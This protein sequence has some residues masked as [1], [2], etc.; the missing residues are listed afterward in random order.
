MSMRTT[1][2]AFRCPRAARLSPLAAAIGLALAPVI[3]P[4]ATITVTSTADSGPGTLRQAIFDANANC[5]SDPSPTIDFTGTGPFTV[6][7]SSQ[8]P[9]FFCP[10]GNFNPT[11]DGGGSI[12]GS[13]P[14]GFDHHAVLNG[15]GSAVCGLTFPANFTYGG[16]LT[17]RGMRI[18]NFTYGSLAAGVCGVMELHENLLTNNTVGAL[19][20][21][22]NAVVGDSTY[23][24][25]VIVN[26][27]YGVWVQFSSASIENNKIGTPNGT[28]AL[29]N[30][31]G[32]YVYASNGTD[33]SNN[34]I[35]GNTTAGVYFDNDYGGTVTGNYIGTTAD[36]DGAL[37]NGTGIYHD[38]GGSSSIQNNVI[39][40]NAGPGIGFNYSTGS[41]IDSNNIGVGFSYGPL[42]NTRGVDAFC[43]GYIDLYS[44]TIAHNNGD[45]VFLNGSESLYFASNVIE[46]N[47]GNGVR[48]T[49]D[50]TESCFSYGSFNSLF[51]NDINGN[52]QNGMLVT[53]L[54]TDNAVHYGSISGNGT[55]N[56]SLNGGTG[57]LPNDSGDSDGGPNH[58]QNWP[59][60]NSVVQGP[61]TTDINVT[62]DADPS[63]MYE[64]QFYA[65]TAL[66]KPGG[67][68]YI[69]STF[70]YGGDTVTATVG[71]VYDNISAT[72][73]SPDI[74]CG[75]GGD[76]SEFSPM[77][78]ALTAPAVLITPGS[79]NF[80]FVELNNSSPT[81]NF[82]VRSV[83]DQPYVIYDIQ[84]G[85]FCYAQLQNKAAVVSSLCSSGGFSCST[86]CSFEADYAKGTGC[87]VSV[88]FTPTFQGFQSDSLCIQD[89][90]AAGQ[91]FIEFSGTG[92]PPPPLV[93]EPTSHDFG[94]VAVGSASESMRFKVTN[95]TPYGSLPVTVMTTGGEFDIVSDGCSPEI[96]PLSDCNID[97]DFAPSA[98]GDQQ[99]E[100]V[101]QGASPPPSFSVQGFSFVQPEARASLQG[102]GVS[103]GQLLLPGSI[104]MGAGQVGGAAITYP[105]ELRNTGYGALTISSIT[106]SSPF[107][108][109]NNCPAT[110]APAQS[111]SLLLGFQATAL[112]EVN[113][114]L[115][116]VT[117]AEGGSRAVPVVARGQ[118]VATPL[119]RVL[120]TSLGFGSRIIGSQSTAQQVTITNI[121]GA[122]ATLDLALSTI[123]FLISGN[124]CGATL[125]PQAS[126]SANVS[127]RPLGFGTRL[128]SFVVNGNA[129]NAPQ[130]LVISG[131][132]CRPF[133][134][135]SSRFS[136]SSSCAP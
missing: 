124:N 53:G 112:G 3:A 15:G 81:T 72:A 93:I 8:L 99:G 115:T 50:S 135:G 11:V 56:I 30:G 28:S 92:T 105:V 109:V 46:S 113:G 34:L 20:N 55:K 26:N 116:V 13:S 47:S 119:L 74:C 25:N 38:F 125:A 66:G 60:V 90:T 88:A 121:G 51:D 126:C 120:P 23:G 10:G 33:I 42:H 14:V 64:V 68:T 75:I 19:A 91:H 96:P 40:G 117:S 94:S 7:V 59:V 61:G 1:T 71:G 102:V 82:T 100:L 65:N 85:S 4:A 27:T 97:V 76:T 134:A 98:S 63:S 104:D 16:Q 83:G 103:G 58:Q 12:N 54:S 131:T 89:N 129:A 111:C 95:R 79:K 84:P 77:K 67:E 36:G 132:G 122:T 130:S 114:T 31:Y 136:T 73:T 45:G 18:Q 57:T 39:S 127:F 110:L 17:V 24:G 6:S 21:D 32:I 128:G 133:A 37:P 29:A 49:T 22:T 2:P 80:G 106:V 69:G 62:L 44:N 43:S 70:M 87:S 52:G 48:I 108:L 41:S 9:S 107:T 123:D 118:T 35:S 5:L 86:T 101:V 78:A